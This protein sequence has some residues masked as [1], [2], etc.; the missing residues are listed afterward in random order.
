M[1]QGTLHPQYALWTGAWCVLGS[2]A[3]M[4]ALDVFMKKYNR[5]SPI[6]FLLA[7]IL[8]ISA[9]LIP[10][11]GAIDLIKNN[12]GNLKIDVAALCK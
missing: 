9:L 5:Q 12:G 8:G 3:G 1:L 4:K 2:I 11:F 10:I 7:A 6:V